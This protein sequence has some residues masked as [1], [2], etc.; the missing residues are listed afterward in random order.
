MT[1]KHETVHLSLARACRPARAGV[2]ALR[3]CVTGASA[4]YA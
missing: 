4:K 2:Q 1:P 3:A